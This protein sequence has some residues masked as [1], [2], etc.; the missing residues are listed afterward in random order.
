MSIT[1]QET[2]I[3]SQILE[4][5]TSEYLAF[6]TSLPKFIK[7]IETDVTIISADAPVLYFN[8]AFN[9]RFNGNAKQRIQE[10]KD[11]FLESG[12]SFVWQ[13]TRSSQPENLGEQLI[14]QGGQPLESM[15]YM[16]LQLDDIRRD[17][18]PPAFH[19]KAVRT[20]ETLYAWTSIY[21]HAR[22]YP[23][24][25]DRL[26]NILSD[27]DLGES[28]PLQ[29]ILGY[30]GDT[31]VA[32][33]SV[34]LGSEAAGFYSLSTLPDARSHGLGT[35]ISVVAAD[36]A[37]DRGYKTAMLLSEH[38]SRNLCKRLGFVEGFGNMDIYRMS[39][40]ADIHFRK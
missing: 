34:F 6:V 7:R 19:W 28:S 27:L 39:A 14:H 2:L 10:T 1:Y 18:I 35:A 24:S 4:N 3:S 22:A 33:Y 36:L 5:G 11:Y 17:S 32:T 30:L 9:P 40:D 21:C 16:A 8:A 31:P 12:R 25:T 20:H 23:E 26:F 37:L 29:L 15:A 38:M 13:V